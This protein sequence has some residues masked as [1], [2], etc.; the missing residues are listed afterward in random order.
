[1]S[2]MAGC[3]L[4]GPAEELLDVGLEIFGEEPA[5]VAP[6]GL[7]VAADQ[8]LLEVPSHVSAGDGTP[9]DVLWVG[10]EGGGV[11]TRD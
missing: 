3:G 9:D 6:E 2:L 10:H 7:S 1:M 5:A 8:E 11:V 4:T